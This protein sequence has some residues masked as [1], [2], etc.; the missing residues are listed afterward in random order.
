M[1]AST[2][3]EARPPRR[4]VPGVYVEPRPRASEPTAVRTDIAGFLGF[5]PR[6]RVNAGSL[7]L[8]EGSPTG[9]VFAVEVVEFQITLVGRTVTVPPK[10]ALILS[11]DEASCP[12]NDGESIAYAVIAAGIGPTVWLVVEGTA[13]VG[14]VPP[15]ASD[16]AIE[17]AIRDQMG[18]DAPWARIADVIARRDGDTIWPYVRPALPPMLCKDYGDFLLK[19]GEPPQDGT[20]LASA[21][22]AYF[23]NGGDRCYIATFG[24]PLF[25]DSVGLRRSLNDLVGVRGAGEAK[26]TGLERLLMVNEVSIIDAPDLYARRVDVEPKRLDLPGRAREACSSRAPRSSARSVLSRFAVKRTSAIRC[27]PP[28]TQFK[29]RSRHSGICSS[30]AFPNVGGCI[31]C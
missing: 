27:S 20:L 2:S 12:I 6:V 14:A 13:A 18:G 4:R 7:R 23:A 9:H 3:F 26:A 22:R 25:F 30:D 5:E 10:A 16:E 24:R 1:T 8:T 29:G 11:E 31:F 17:Q 15:P 19:F 21:V 28:T